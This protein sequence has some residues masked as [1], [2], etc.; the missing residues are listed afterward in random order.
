M[1]DARLGVGL[2]L[3][4][5]PD[6]AWRYVDVPPH[7]RGVKAPFKN[8][9]GQVYGEFALEPFYIATYPVTYK[10]FQAFT[11]AAHG[12]G[13]D[14]WWQGLTEQYHKQEVLEQRTP[15]DN[16]PRDSVSWYQC[17]AYTRWLNAKYK[18]ETLTN[19]GNSSARCIVGENAEI[20]LPL[21]WEWQW[22]AQGNDGRDYP[23]GDWD[24]RFTNTRE[25]RL[26]RTTAVG[27][28][29]Q[30]ASW[31]GA[32]DMR[33][34]LWEWCLNEQEPAIRTVAAQQLGTARR[35]ARRCSD[36]AVCGY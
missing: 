23:W 3:D 24:G 5:L 16:H 17:V 30:G 4:G 11:D 31:C 6:I 7:L 26:S 10:Q 34:S 9:R 8:E 15:F 18:G 33:G 29:P 14:G 21:E 13:N 22:A 2:R 27:M 28:Y 32:L 1:G 25:C 20:R 36:W 19:P 35:V 12:F